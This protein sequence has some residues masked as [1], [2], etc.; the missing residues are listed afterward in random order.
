MTVTYE[1]FKESFLNQMLVLGENEQ[2]QYILDLI[3]DE[4]E[5]DIIHY[6]I[7]KYEIIHS[8]SFEDHKHRYLFA[9]LKYIT[10]QQALNLY[11]GLI[12]IEKEKM[13]SVIIVD[14][15]HLDEL[16]NVHNYIMLN[17]VIPESTIY[18]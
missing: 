18:S 10:M 14:H 11:D 3:T 12:D 13:I 6:L 15:P 2:I 9:Y 7:T 4:E 17:Q 5:N 8:C 1:T 16:V